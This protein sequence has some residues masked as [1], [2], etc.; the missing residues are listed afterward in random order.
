VVCKGTLR[1]YSLHFS[2]FDTC[3][4]MLMSPKEISRRATI[5]LQQISQALTGSLCQP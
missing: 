2:L 4:S 1:S 3:D 5:D